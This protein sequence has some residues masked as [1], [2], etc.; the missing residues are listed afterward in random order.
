MRGVSSFS[1]E[2]G[3]FFSLFTIY[4]AAFLIYE[5]RGFSD[6]FVIVFLM[7]LRLRLC[8]LLPKLLICL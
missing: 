7:D 1:L 6:A 4:L 5:W 3:V 2:E 8:E